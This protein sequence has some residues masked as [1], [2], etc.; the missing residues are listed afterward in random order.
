MDIFK[1]EC[2]RLLLHNLKNDSSTNNYH[3]VVCIASTEPEFK[4]ISYKKGGTGNVLSV[5]AVDESSIDNPKILQLWNDQA[6]KFK[7][8]ILK[9]CVLLLSHFELTEWNRNLIIK[10]SSVTILTSSN[11]DELCSSSS[12]ALPLGNELRNLLLIKDSFQCQ[13]Y[14][15]YPI[16]NAKSLKHAVG[17][18]LINISLLVSKESLMNLDEPTPGPFKSARY[19][20]SMTED[21]RKPK[22]IS[23]QVTD[24]Y[25][26]PC[27][28]NITHHHKAQ[29]TNTLLKNT[30]TPNR[31]NKDTKIHF[32]FLAKNIEVHSIYN[33]NIT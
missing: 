31:P 16:I 26:C 19:I 29:L 15:I 25:G 17:F 4:C 33:N 14:H 7:H 9:G 2:R 22:Y 23:L 30:N 32:E 10:D 11:I 3:Y 28:L 20:L 27:L 6:T 8:R 13:Q 12:S 5:S 18:Y 24:K 1:S 21:V